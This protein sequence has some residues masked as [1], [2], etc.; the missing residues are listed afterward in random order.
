MERAAH[1]PVLGSGAR[2]VTGTMEQSEHD[3]T[4]G[5][6]GALRFAGAVVDLTPPAGTRLAGYL[7]RGDAVATGTHDPLQAIIVWLRDPR[8]DGGQVVWVAIDALAV[9]ADQAGAIAGAVGA[10]LGCDPSDVLV[11][12]THTH[13][14]PAGWNLGLRGIHPALQEPGD[15]GMRHAVVTAV[16]ATAARLLRS[17]RPVRVISA[18]G[19]ATD[20]GS[21]RTDPAG[22]HDPSVGVLG[23]VSPCG[24]VTGVLVDYACHATVLGHANLQWSADWPGAARRT[25]AAA[26]MGIAPFAAG[27]AASSSSRDRAATLASSAAGDLDSA[28][29]V[30]VVQGAAGDASARFVRRNQ[31]FG[32]VDRLGGLLSAHALTA[33]FEGRPHLDVTPRIVVRHERLE[34]STRP[35]PSPADARRDAHDTEVAWRRVAELEGPGPLE[36]VARTRHEGA[37]LLAAV[38]EHGLPPRVEVP[39]TVVALGDLAFVHMPVELFA[40]F[41]LAIRAASPFARTRVV[42][43]TDGYFGYVA[44]AAAHTAGVYEASASLFDAEGGARLVDAAVELLQRAHAEVHAQPCTSP[45]AQGTR[46]RP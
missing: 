41:G 17:D 25:L 27:D 8:P 34:L 33:L 4:H 14:A 1:R 30:A 45:D 19:R 13:S 9:D 7:A 40:S 46:G 26:L 2:L 22:P 39:I 37:L 23:L 42:G 12:A 15:E 3:V 10:A 31:T 43:Y 11:C 32:E 35:L 21:N 44:D 16:A 20:V 24:R 18:E 38:A 36:R 28:P 29:I 5:S 6:E